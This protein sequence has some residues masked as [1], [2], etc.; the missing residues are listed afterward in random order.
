MQ[1][2][3]LGNQRGKVRLPPLSLSGSHFICVSWATYNVIIDL[4]STKQNTIAFKLLQTDAFVW[5]DPSRSSF[6]I[7]QTREMTIVGDADFIVIRGRRLR[8]T[9]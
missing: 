2:T 8:K 3:R 9:Q 7:Q 1:E 6:P 5:T 4:A